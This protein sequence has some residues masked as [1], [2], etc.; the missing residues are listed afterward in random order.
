MGIFSFNSIYNDCSNIHIGEGFEEIYK[1]KPYPS[2][3]NYFHL[4]E[5]G[6]IMNLLLRLNR[7]QKLVAI[8]G[9]FAVKN[10]FTNN[11]GTGSDP[12]VQPSMFYLENPPEDF[13]YRFICGIASS[14]TGIPKIMQYN[15]G[16]ISTAINS[17]FPV[18]GYDCTSSIGI[19]VFN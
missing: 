13:T 3:E 12:N 7:K 5:D 19:L 14:G 8:T 17:S 16:E 18:G 11:H 6:T 4:N 15:N 1:F 10:E 9:Y 2:I